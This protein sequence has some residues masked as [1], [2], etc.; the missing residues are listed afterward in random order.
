MVDME[1]MTMKGCSASSQFPTL[2]EPHHQIALCHIQDTCRVEA[3]PFCRGAVGVFYSPSQLGKREPVP[4]Y[5]IY[6]ERNNSIQIFLFIIVH[7]CISPGNI[8]NVEYSFI[9][10]THMSTLNLIGNTWQSSISGTNRIVQLFTKDCFYW[11]FE[12][13]KLCAN[14]LH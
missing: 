3:L 6:I 12:L 8:G 13:I 14:Q 9:A 2:L 5:D 4:L 10:I 7:I 11:F 1:A